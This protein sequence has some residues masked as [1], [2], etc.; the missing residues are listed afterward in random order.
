MHRQIFAHVRLMWAGLFH[1]AALEGDLRK[2]RDV[3]ELRAAQMIVSPCGLG[4]DARRLNRRGDGDFSGWSRS[5]SM[6]LHGLR[7]LVHDER[8]L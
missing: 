7:L 4:I 1:T 3:N 5:T 8:G 2:L 6:A